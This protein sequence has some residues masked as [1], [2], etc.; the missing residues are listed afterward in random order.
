M[1]R[2]TARPDLLDFDRPALAALFEEWGI[3]TFHA[4]RVWT[5]LYREKVTEISAMI[6]LRADLRNRLLAETT[7]QWPECVTA[8]ESADGTRKF[9]LRLRDGEVVEAV[10]MPYRDR[11]TACIST[12]V[13]CAMGCVFCATGQMGFTRHLSAGEIVGQILFLQEQAAKS[14]R[15]LRNIVFMGMGEPLHNYDATVKAIDIL[16]DDMGL[17]FGP[18]HLTLSTVGMPAGIRR[19]ADEERPV[20]LAVSLHGATDEQRQAL[21]PIASRWP[22]ADLLDACRYYV[23]K[24]GRR[25]FFEWTLIAGEN[26]TPEQAH[27]LGRLLQGIDAHVNVIPLNPTGQYDGAPSAFQAIREFKVILDSYGVPSTVRQRRGIDIDAGCGQL[28]RRAGLS[29][30]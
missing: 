7:L 1:S 25:I 12:Q 29:Q 22:L 4:E 13:G 5:Y 21:I 20:N 28:R 18:R 11:Y 30:A 16:T 24:R 14:T 9:L 17:A 8:Q 19:L 23:S 10:L 27:A 2:D 3:S 6:A 26:D 15:D